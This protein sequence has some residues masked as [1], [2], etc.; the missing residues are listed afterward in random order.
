MLSPWLME[1][2]Y[3][4]SAHSGEEWWYVTL[5]GSSQGSLQ[6]SSPLIILHHLA[7]TLWTSDFRP[8]LNSLHSTSLA[9]KVN[10]H[11]LVTGNRG[12][13]SFWRFF[14]ATDSQL[15][16]YHEQKANTTIDS[17]TTYKYDLAVDTLDGKGVT[18]GILMNSQSLC[19]SGMAISMSE[20][21]FSTITPNFCLK[22]LRK[23]YTR[24]SRDE[25][26][27]RI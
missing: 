20:L 25:V 9:G 8:S 7:S 24:L 21:L 11:P 13:N 10:S 5:V 14:K 26:R 3:I 23:W 17:V 1:M 12:G 22:T 19:T 15:S 2:S 6:L 27:K 4:I 16:F 18:R